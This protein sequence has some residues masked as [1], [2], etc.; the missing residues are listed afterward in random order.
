MPNL[1]DGKLS[2][3]VLAWSPKENGPSTLNWWKARFYSLSIGVKTLLKLPWA[4]QAF[5]SGLLSLNQSIKFLT[6]EH[7]S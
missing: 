5:Y 7:K 4:D 1:K 2:A 6:H 3:P